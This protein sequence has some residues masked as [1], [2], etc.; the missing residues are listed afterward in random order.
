[1][2]LFFWIFRGEPLV[3]GSEKIPSRTPSFLEKNP[4]TLTQKKCFKVATVNMAPGG[5]RS[6]VDVCQ[7]STT[8]NRIMLGPGG[9]PPP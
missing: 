5:V 8:S 7:I 6:T 1:M 4:V 2:I 9:I 3:P